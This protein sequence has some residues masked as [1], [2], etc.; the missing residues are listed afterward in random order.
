[1]DTGKFVEFPPGTEFGDIMELD[2]TGLLVAPGFI[3]IQNNGS[4]VRAI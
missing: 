3:D 1:M 2:C 4:F